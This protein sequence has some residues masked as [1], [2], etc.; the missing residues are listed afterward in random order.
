M[1]KDMLLQNRWRCLI[2]TLLILMFLLVLAPA[3][4]PARAS[5]SELFFSEYIEGSGNN[6]AL[7]I[8]NGTGA[9]VDLAAGG[10]SIQMSFNG[11]T[12][13]YTINLTGTVADG[14]VY[15]VAPTNATDDTILAQADQLQ[16]TS[17]FNGDDAIVLLRG[18]VLVDVIGQI[19]FDPGSEWG[20][21]LTSTQDNTLRR[22]SGILAGDTNSSDVFDPA[23]EWDGFA[24]NTFD[25]LGSHATGPVIEVP[26]INEFVFNHTGIDTYEYVE[27]LGTPDTDYTTYT[28]I[29]IEGDSPDAG[30]IDSVLPVGIT[31]ANGCWLSGYLADGF[32]NGTVTLLLVDGFIGSQG[33]DLDSDDNGTLDVLPWS[34]IADSVAVSD[35]GADDWGYAAATLSPGFDGQSFTPGGASRIPDGGTVW[36]RNDFDGAGLPGFGGSIAVGEAYN[37]PG[38]ANQVYTQPSEVCGDPFTPI[39]T[40]QGSTAASLLDGSEITTEGIVTG[41]FQN[42]DQKSGFFLQDAAGD[43]DT[44]TSDGIFVYATGIDVNA[45]D[46]VRVRGT[47]DEYYNL[48]EITSVSLIMICST[49]NS[50]PDATL[51]S[52]PVTSL[53]DF[54]PY[55][56][57]LVVFPQPLSISEYFEFDRYGEIVL[58]AGR[59]YQPTSLFEP[60]S[61]EAAQLAQDNLLGRITLD[62]GRSVQ[63]PD[64]ARHPNGGIFD[65]N[66]L[67]RGGDVLQNVIGVLD[68]SYDLWRIQPTQGADYLSV[69]PRVAQPDGVGGT[70]KVASFNVL[71]YFTTLNSRGAKTPEEFARQQAKIVAALQTIDADVA[72]LI[73]IENNTEA[74][75]NLVDAL[76]AVMGAGT[77]AYVDTGPIGVDEIRVA[78]IY[79]PADVSL[80][81]SYTVLDASVDSRFID[82]KNRPALAQTFRDNATGGVFTVVVNHLKSKGSDCIDIGDPDLGDGA[83]NCNLTRKAAV[84]ALVD[85]LAGDPTGSSS[86]AF[87]IIGDMNSYAKEDPIDAFKAGGY[88][89]LV[90]LFQGELA[91]SYVFDGQLGY[92]DHALASPSLLDKVTGVVDWHINADE[93]D[94]IDYDM[95]YKQDAQD[96]IYAPDAYRASDHD[97]VVI[98][99]SMQDAIAPTLSVSVSPQWLWQANHKYV[100]VVATVIAADN[101]D[102]N[103]T[104]TLLS[105]TSSEA[106]SGLWP[107]DRPNDIIIVDDLTFRLRAER[108]I[109]GFGRVYTMM[110]QVTDA[111]GNTTIA[112]APVIVPRYYW[113]C[114]W[115]HGW[116]WGGN[117]RDL[118]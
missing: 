73:E 61:P 45:G 106:D 35:G 112:G 98:G 26:Q 94:L 41:D 100:D 92:L 84:E 77:Y 99:L 80:A 29:Q 30:L 17:W 9:A 107:G 118:R 91:Y 110:Y 103:P 59:Q 48:T 16:G 32:E 81:G 38:M 72:G 20:S 66:N 52:L 104:V 85:W 51:L 58:T 95:T 67:F 83:G 25:G 11:G 82:T 56:G 18:G 117:Y 76:N 97:P 87:L 78:I 7:E 54:E 70:L 113:G 5:A 64:P 33:M 22:K 14:D 1:S 21:S 31:D 42:S 115:C 65:L 12:S 39:Y 50:L 68:Y 114:W 105:V 60:G 111:A 71:N 55:E 79:K 40:I 116:A 37:T 23:V 15:V 62:D 2:T 10:Y 90:S 46:A 109:Y 24:N 75:Q 34:M 44:A 19:G 47:V 43:G 3:R 93:P 86:D 96:T 6:K 88:T 63:N 27:V 74:I 8:H 36:V 57:M 13:T 101:V 102:P 4:L 53:D 69:N 108:W 89:D 49:G 28:L